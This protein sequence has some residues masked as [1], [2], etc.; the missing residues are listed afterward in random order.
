MN[1]AQ[2]KKIVIQVASFADKLEDEVTADDVATKSKVAAINAQ[3][4]TLQ[5]QLNQ[6]V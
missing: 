4:A 6:C 2:F 3:I 5:A 1:A